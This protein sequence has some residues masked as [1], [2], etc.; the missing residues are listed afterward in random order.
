MQVSAPHTANPTTEMNAMP[1]ISRIKMAAVSK[2]RQKSLQSRSLGAR[3]KLGETGEFERRPSAHSKAHV[4]AISCQAQRT[5]SASLWWE[6]M[7]LHRTPQIPPQKRMPGS[8]WLDMSKQVL[9]TVLKGTK[10]LGSNL[11]REGRIYLDSFRPLCR[12]S[13]KNVAIVL[14][15]PTNHATLPL[16]RRYLSYW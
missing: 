15:V 5:F 14:R 4:Y 16:E 2:W 10:Y 1:T 11:I 12:V 13:K 9:F 7:F 8:H 3:V 6:C